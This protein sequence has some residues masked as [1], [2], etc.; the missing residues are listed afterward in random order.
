MSVNIHPQNTNT[1]LQNTSISQ[2]TDRMGGISSRY[3]PIDTESL[4]N[5]VIADIGL[6]ATVGS[7]SNL[8][9][10]STKH[11]VVLTLTNPV[12]LAGTECLPRIYVRNSYAGESALTI[13]VGFYRF[14]CAN[15]MMVGTTHFNGRLL[16]LESGIKQLPELRRSIT[17]AVQWLVKDLPLLANRLNSVLLTPAQIQSIL[18]SVNA[19][20]RLAEA[21]TTR[22]SMPLITIRPEDRRPDGALTAWN[23]WNLINELQRQRSRSQLRP[24]HAATVPH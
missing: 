16:H 17:G 11:A 14:I 2:Y 10:R 3:R 24:K 7:I 12:M 19:S 1:H 13:R 4:V 18:T 5:R 9:N 15:G 20:K 6:P 23:V 8:G 21:V 22:V